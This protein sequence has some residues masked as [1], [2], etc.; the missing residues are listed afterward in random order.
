[1]EEQRAIL[2]LKRGDI[3]GLEPLVRR[4][5]LRAVHTAAL[6]TRDRALAEDVVQ[7]AFL[8]AY[9]RIGQ[10]DAGRPFGPWFLRSVV[11]DA[12][13]AVRRAHRQ[14]PLQHLA[15]AAQGPTDRSAPLADLDGM[16]LDLLGRAEEHEAIRAALAQL[17]PEHRAVI[18]QRYF[19]GLS[20]REMAEVLHTPAGTIKSRLN[21]ARAGLRQR[22]RPVRPSAAGGRSMSGISEARGK[23]GRGW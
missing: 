2:R 18:V 11:N 7:T 10:F 8:R 5:Q 21:A 3:G 20:E 9:E 6:I 12:L 13:K 19:L 23:R 1:M 4:Y 14:I 16:P 17:S 22:L 15:G